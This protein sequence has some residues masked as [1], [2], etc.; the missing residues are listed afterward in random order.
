MAARKPRA[1]KTSRKSEA[2][3]GAKENSVEVRTAAKIGDNS[4]LKL[5]APADFDHHYK[6]MRGAKE[7][8]ATAQALSSQASESANKCSPGLAAVIKN[9]LKIEAE[10]DPAKLQRHLEMMG[11]GLKHIGSSV[12]MTIFD[13]L[14]G[15][16]ADQAYKRGFADGEAPRAAANPYPEGS[17]LYADYAKGWRE[18]TAKNLGLSD[19]EVAAAF[20]EGEEHPDPDSLNGAE[21]PDQQE[22]A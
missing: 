16:V 2:D 1:R 20:P 17:D 6:S 13:T 9:T 11:M 15:D 7:K 10:N 22:A 14:A 3:T 19:E 5:P 12:Q 21:E 8:V 18:G 4:Q